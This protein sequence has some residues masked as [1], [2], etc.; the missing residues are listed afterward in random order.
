MLSPANR[1]LFDVENI[2]FS[3]WWMCSSKVFDTIKSSCIISFKPDSA[4]LICVFFWSDIGVILSPDS[5]GIAYQEEKQL[6]DKPIITYKLR[7]MQAQKTKFISNRKPGW[8]Q[9]CDATEN[10]PSWYFY[11]AKVYDLCDAVL[12]NESNRW[13]FIVWGTKYG[14]FTTINISKY[15]HFTRKINRMLLTSCVSVVFS[16]VL[17]RFKLDLSPLLFL[18]WDEGLVLRRVPGCND[19]RS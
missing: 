15:E 6:Q 5:L 7:Q 9:I 14:R 2:Y 11:S 18:L 12:S 13:K 10:L 3:F 4:T 16:G 1:Q 8:T 19:L 17:C